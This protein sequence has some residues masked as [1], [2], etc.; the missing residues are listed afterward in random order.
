MN[1]IFSLR[2]H[3]IAI[4]AD[5]TKIVTMFIK[6]SLKTQKMLK[7]LQIMYRNAINN[8]IF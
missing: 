1:R 7:E 4:F 6:T 5:L 8:C 2:K 3:R